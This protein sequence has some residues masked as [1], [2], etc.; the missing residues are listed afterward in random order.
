MSF[1]AL[2][3]PQFLQKELSASRVRNAKQKV[4]IG[5]K[6]V[7]RAVF[8]TTTAAVPHHNTASKP[9]PWERTSPHSQSNTRTSIVLDEKS[10]SKIEPAVTTPG[11]FVA[12]R[13]AF[14]ERKFQSKIFPFIKSQRVKDFE[15]A[16]TPARQE[17]CCASFHF[18]K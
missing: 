15:A 14:P 7:R 2:R 16:F 18:E 1:V 17:S 8:S 11:G 4:K 3:S 13:A 12:N 9:R 5:D 6:H 10:L